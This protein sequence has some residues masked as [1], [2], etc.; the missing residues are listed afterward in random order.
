LNTGDAN[1]GHLKTE[2]IIKKLNKI[3]L[4]FQMVKPFEN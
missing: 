4:R 2:T 1:T 3:L